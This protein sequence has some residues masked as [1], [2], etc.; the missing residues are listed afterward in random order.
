MELARA[1]VDNLGEP[2]VHVE[3]R[4]LISQIHYAC[5]I[6]STASVNALTEV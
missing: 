6:S 3:L 1:V 4:E 5:G 2:F